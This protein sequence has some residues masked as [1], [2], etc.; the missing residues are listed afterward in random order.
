MLV[1]QSM[2]YASLARMPPVTGLYS[3]IV[4]LVVYAM[5]GTSG[6]LAV[7]PV[8]ITALMTSAALAPLAKGDPA[9]YIALAGL[10]AVLVGAVQLL[11][12]LLRGGALVGFLSHSV[13]AR[14][15]SAAAIVIAASQVPLACELTAWAQMLALAEH[16]ARRWEPKRRRPRPFRS[17]RRLVRTGRCTR[18]T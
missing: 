11:L 4:P 5:L 14:F 17:P 9:R 1:P 3:A 18:C 15:T 16:P 12:G 7:G 8:A 6:A 2:A 10:L 13:L